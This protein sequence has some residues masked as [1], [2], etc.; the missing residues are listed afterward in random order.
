MH[1]CPDSK[2]KNYDRNIFFYHLHCLEHFT[3]QMIYWKNASNNLCTILGKFVRHGFIS[4]LIKITFLDIQSKNLFF[5]LMIVVVVH[6]SIYFNHLTKHIKR[7]ILNKIL[8]VRY[9]IVN[10]TSFVKQMY[11]N[12][13]S[14]STKNLY[15]LKSKITHFPSL[16][17]WQPQHYSLV[18]W[19]W[20][21][22]I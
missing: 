14:G 1:S 22:C 11:W 12:F 9:V 7:C 13:S 21:L 5:I 16:K 8:S 17:P 4:I 18:L 15:P 3:L 19:I 6:L 20:L 2:L 10:N